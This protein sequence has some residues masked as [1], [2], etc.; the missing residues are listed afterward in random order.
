MSTPKRERPASN[1]FST[2]SN[3][4]MILR[5]LFKLVFGNHPYAYS[6]LSLGFALVLSFMWIS[7]SSAQD[8][9]AHIRMVRALEMDRLGI[10]NPAGL[11]F[12]QKAQA[13]QVLESQRGSTPSFAVSDI[14]TISAREERIAWTRIPT[15]VS[16]PINM[17][18]DDK[19]DRL[20]ILQANA[21]QV[22]EIKA[23]PDG[24]LNCDKPARFDVRRFGLQNPQGMAVD[25][26]TG[27]L[28]ILDGAASSLVRITPASDGSFEE[29]TVSR[30]EPQPA[31]VAALAGDLRGLAFDP[32]SG[33]LHV[34]NPAARALYEISNTGQVVATRDLSSFSLNDPQ[35]MVFAP[36]GDLTDDPAQMDL[37]VADGSQVVEFSFTPLVMVAT[38]DSATL[39]QTI[40]TSAFV[41]PSPDTAGIAYI[42]ASDTF[43][44]SDSEVNEIS[45]LFT[46]DNLFEMTAS[47]TLIDTTTTTSFSD[48]PTGVAYNPGNGHVFFS[49][50]DA[51]EVYEIAPGVDGQYGTGDDSVTHFDTNAFSSRDPEGITFDRLQGVLFI[52]D[53]NSA[54]VYRVAPGANGVFDG[55]APAG[56]DQVSH[57]DTA[58]LGITDP[59]GITFSADSGNLFIVGMPATSLAEIT[60]SG[61]LVNMHDI[62][63]AN[64][65]KP[66]GLG[67][68]PGS[69]DPETMNIYIAERGVDNNDDPNENDGKIYEVSLP[70]A[71]P[72]NQ[73]PS[74]DAGD[75]QTITLSQSASLVG[76]VSDDGLPDPPAAVTVLWS[77][78][79]GPGT[80][81]FADANAISTTASFSS[82]GTYVLRLTADDSG[83][84]ASDDVK[85]YVNPENTAPLAGDDAYTMNEDAALNVAAPG[86]LGNDTDGENDSLTAALV[87]NVSNGSLTLNA[88]G[89]FNYTPNH[90]F[91]GT[92]AFIYV[93]NDGTV[94]SNVATVTIT[95]TAVN[96]P[97]AAGDDAYTISEDAELNVAAPGVLGNDTDGENDSLTAALVSNI[98][99]GS[100]TLNAN[101]SFNYTPNHNFN[102]ADTFTYVANDGTANSNLATVTI[103]VTAVNDPPVAGDDTYM[104]YKDVPLHVAATGV[105]GN[106][107]DLDGDALTVTLVSDVSNGSLTLNSD[108]SFNYTPNH[109]FNGTDT[110][111][112]AANDGTANSNVATVTIIL[113]ANI[114]LP[115]IVSLTG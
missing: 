83:L 3:S 51:R 16:D 110:F 103:T 95:V 1:I 23:R 12:S 62:S 20:L 14:S 45:K 17:T 81:S 69:V 105:L 67:Y 31:G 79:S 10:H 39:V 112:Y 44:F 98:S 6:R 48:E 60:T 46:G 113:K 92:D 57:F 36:S 50:D 54:E 8:G 25:P 15:A 107:S 70:S 76:S 56:D 104:A 97:P 75:D 5:K 30:L 90:N 111:T 22:I 28:F 4:K 66:A 78:V 99:N 100:L 59:E 88:N 73:P 43:L 32:T 41:P 37:Y 40:D 91:N 26:A 19:F 106:D 9:A 77:K 71:A 29:A 38:T 27:D 53:G 101:G 87:S 108:G 11:V 68:G 49:D 86:V 94:D 109:N 24:G 52:V 47:G 2:K 7:A 42:D 18:F 93:A 114:Y 35:G 80:V 84:M 21:N 82:T 72:P 64:A 34:L 74:V 102:G 33:H 115:I 58:S 96:D 61:A 85:V 13:F 65:Y 55:V 89:S 63:A